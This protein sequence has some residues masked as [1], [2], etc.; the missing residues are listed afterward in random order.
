MQRDG[1]LSD[2]SW[3]LQIT[4]LTCF[5][6]LDNGVIMEFD[7]PYTLLQNQDGALYNL[8]Q[9]TGKM[10]AAAL[11]KAAKEVSTCSSVPTRPLGRSVA[12]FRKHVFVAKYNGN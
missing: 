10:E 1:L 6:V 2:G 12:R 9:Q 7:D 3:C 8:V 4:P 5:Q 11:L